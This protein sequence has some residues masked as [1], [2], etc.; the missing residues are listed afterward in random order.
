MKAPHVLGIAAL[1]GLAVGLVFGSHWMGHVFPD[2]GGHGPWY[3]SRAAGFAA[4]LALWAALLVGI[5]MSSTWLDGIVNRARLFAA[6]QTL[7]F[8]GVAFVF[9]HAL[10]LIP[11][12]WT[13]FSPVDLFVPFASSFERLQTG[14]GTVALWLFAIVT[15]SFW[16]RTLIGPAM[17]RLIHY[18]SVLAY[19]AA[20]WHG[21]RLGT[22]TAEWWAALLYI[23]TVSVLLGAF[24]T[25][26]TYSR[27]RRQP[28]A[29][30]AAGA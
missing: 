21:V 30:A 16:V 14:V 1:V 2:A 11:D 15:F 6:H 18:S 8:V 19:M 24:A 25:R 29:K 23:V 10:V 22:D 13:A 27:P 3:A 20:L 4:Y 7:A 28:R 5:V 12:Q 17:W 9:A 26:F